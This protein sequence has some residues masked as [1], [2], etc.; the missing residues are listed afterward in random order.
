MDFHVGQKVYKPKGYE[1][2]GTV[3]SVFQNLN[4]D[5]RLVV[6]HDVSRGMLHIFAPSQVEPV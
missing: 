3:V 5:T 1:F 4:G 2:P 6:E